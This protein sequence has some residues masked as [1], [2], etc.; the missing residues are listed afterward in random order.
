ME[1]NILVSGGTGSGKTSLL[2]AISG[3]IS[4]TERVIVIEDSSE[5]QLQQ[6]HV[7]SFE[8]AWPD[9]HGQGAVG[10]RDLFHSALRMRPDRIIIGECRGGE[11][12]DLIQAMTSGHGGSMST[13]HANTPLD[14]LNRLE[15][16]ALMSAVNIPLM[17]LRSQI[18]SAID[19]IIQVSRLNDGRRVVTEI[20]EVDALSTEN[21]YRVNQIFGHVESLSDGANNAAVKLSWSGRQSVFGDRMKLLGIA[22]SAELTRKIFPPVEK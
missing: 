15:T 19:V 11:A 5:L 9:R 17:A 1:H 3:K 16:M 10:I 12:L 22:T 18:V 2:N 8:T 20:C 6:P 4:E 21:Q 13:L 14:A 7:L